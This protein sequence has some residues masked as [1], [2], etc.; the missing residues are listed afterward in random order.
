[1]V[2]QEYT[3]ISR[4]WEE[5]WKATSIC[6]FYNFNEKQNSHNESKRRYA[7]LEIFDFQIFYSFVYYMTK[8]VPNI[9]FVFMWLFIIVGSF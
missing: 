2:L 4:L 5:E 3:M 8:H 9:D 6:I 7:K 1:M